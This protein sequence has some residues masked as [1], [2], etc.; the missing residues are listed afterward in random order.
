MATHFFLGA[1]SEDFQYVA[2]AVVEDPPF[3]CPEFLFNQEAV[4]Q[5]INSA[6]ETG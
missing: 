2:M 4:G 1:F 6:L 5:W 3:W